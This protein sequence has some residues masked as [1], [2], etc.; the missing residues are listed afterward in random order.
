MAVAFML[1]HPY[2]VARVMSSYYWEQNFEG[3]S[4]TNDWVNYLFHNLCVITT[5]LYHDG[6]YYIDGT[7]KHRW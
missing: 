2:G 3:G 5:R 1:A 4:D 6:M 7:T